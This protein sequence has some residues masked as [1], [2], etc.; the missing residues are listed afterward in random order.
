MEFYNNKNFPERRRPR[1]SAEFHRASGVSDLQNKLL[2][3]GVPAI[4]LGTAQYR[5]SNGGG[6]AKGPSRTSYASAPSSYA[7]LR[8][9]YQQLPSVSYIAPPVP[10]SCSCGMG[11]AGFPGMPGS[12]G[13]PGNYYYN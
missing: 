7:A 12:D 10:Q 2:N 3:V 1:R 4:A 11:A 13:Y 6:Y 9:G 5:G 8:N